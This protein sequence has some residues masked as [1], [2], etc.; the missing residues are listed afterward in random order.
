[1]ARDKYHGLVR[2]ALEKEGWKITHDP[3][4]VPIQISELE[5][6]IGAEMIEAVRG[7][8]LIAVEIKSFLNKSK[9]HDFYK[10]IGQYTFYAKALSYEAPERELYLA[11]PLNAYEYLFRDPISNEIIDEL[12]IQMIIY[13]E[14]N[15]KIK[16]WIT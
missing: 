2:K 16:Q 12:G 10:A 6:D 15:G 1:M 5:I 7:K 14:E 9:L 8:S 13:N 3:L 11:I 4:I